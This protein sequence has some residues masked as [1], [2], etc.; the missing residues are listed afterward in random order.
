MGS[1]YIT[2]ISRRSL[3]PYS[4]IAPHTNSDG[5][6]VMVSHNRT[7]CCVVALEWS[8][9]VLLRN[10]N[11]V[12]YGG[13]LWETTTNI[14]LEYIIPFIVQCFYAH[15]LW[16]M[17]GRDTILI[18]VVVFLSSSLFVIGL[19]CSFKVPV[20]NNPLRDGLTGAASVLAV[21]CDALITASV[22]F[23]L[24]PRSGVKRTQNHIQRIITVTINMGLLTWSVAFGVLVIWCIQGSDVTIVTP[25]MVMAPTYVNSILAVLN[26]RK[27][28]RTTGRNHD[29][30]A[31]SIRLSNMSTIQ[32]DHE[33]Q[34]ASVPTHPAP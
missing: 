3:S 16:I 18:L 10:N 2:T 20:S 31:S 33:S 9:I 28:T 5:G 15:R 30:V 22:Y 4:Q 1:K 24:R 25:I 13:M 12:D 17:S 26:A 29:I 19:V 6:D 34:I 11:I 7:T 23:Y 27:P 32:V 14:S 8:S 21:A